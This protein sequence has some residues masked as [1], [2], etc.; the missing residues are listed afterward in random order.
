M[1]ITLSVQPQSRFMFSRQ[2]IGVECTANSIVTTAGVKFSR[3]ITFIQAPVTSGVVFNITW[4]GINV[5]MTSQIGAIT[6]DGTRYRT[7]AIGDTLADW[8]AHFAEDIG[9]NFYIARDFDITY[10]STTLTLTGKEEGSSKNITFNDIPGTVTT[11]YTLGS[12]TT[13]VDLVEKTNYRIFLDVYIASDDVVRLEMF[14]TDKV[15]TGYFEAQ[16]QKVLHSKITSPF[17]SLTDVS[18]V[19]VLN[20]GELLR[21]YWLRYFEHYGETAAPYHYYLE[22]NSGKYFYALMGG[23]YL[24]KEQDYLDN[25]STTIKFLTWQKRTK[26]V[27]TDQPEWLYWFIPN[28]DSLYGNLELKIYYTDASNDTINYPWDISSEDGLRAMYK[29]VGYFQIVAPNADEGKT[30][31]HWTITIKPT[32]EVE[33]FTSGEVFTYYPVTDGTPW[34][35]HIVFR[36][37]FGAYDTLRL[38]GV[39]STGIDITGEIFNKWLDD[40]YNPSDGMYTNSEFQNQLMHTAVIGFE[41]E[42]QLIDYLREI[43]VNPKAAIVEED[44]DADD[45]SVI[46]TPIVIEPRSI[47]VKRS[48][49]MLFSFEFN[50]KQA[51]DDK[52]IYNIL[53]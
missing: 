30:V 2:P 45:G 48:D 53:S 46:V 28:S 11:D 12:E 13:G 10:T 44:T 24:S 18:N 26:Y 5:I 29:A 20:G 31:D 3:T 8:I 32:D 36:N 4:D 7:K 33:P 25:Y 34:Y 39:V 21:K 42:E 27:T 22:T 50:Y 52:G 38:N 47:K 1:S 49:D 37:S 51:F 17:P 14:R 40:D 9:Y 16:I 23:H 6:E 35:K 15:A 19:L 43:F 41:V